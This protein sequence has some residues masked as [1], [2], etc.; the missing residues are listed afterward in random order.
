LQVPWEI[1]RELLVK[2]E[3]ETDP[4][5][6]HDP[7]K[8]PLDLY[9]KYGVINLDK[10]PGPTSHEV[11]VWIKR[12][13]KVEHAGHGGTLDPPATGILPIALESAT[14]ALQALLLTGKEYVCVM[15]LHG[16]V[17]DNKLREIIN[18]FTGQ[19]Y[20]RPPL[21]ASVKR[22]IRKRTIYY[23][24]ILERE[25]NFVLLRVGCEAGTYIRKLCHDIGEV[26]GC[27]AHMQ[28]LRRIRVGPFSED[29]TLSTLYDLAYAYLTFEESKDEHLLRKVIQPVEAS[30]KLIPKVYVR[31]SAVDAICH[32]AM[33]AAPGVLKVETGI[34]P[35]D[36]IAVLTLKGE[37][38]GLMK[39]LVNTS[40]M[41][42]MDRG[43]VA[44][45]IRVIMA[46]GT[47]PRGW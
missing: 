27:G 47:Y 14:K 30:L 45:P 3:A 10:P 22:R 11:V 19:I 28:E 6:G 1:K 29:E 41:L 12:I 37:A 8:R 43:V 39:A 26:L 21:R 2:E 46:R 15:K 7:K 42:K 44:S 36:M 31:D 17:S 33:L 16:P 24:D 20:Q 34:K 9:I 13:L 18:E 38:I 25:N 32:G 4:R 35:G 23:I 5:F 40:D